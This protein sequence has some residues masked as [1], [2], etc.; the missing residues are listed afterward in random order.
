MDYKLKVDK[1]GMKPML[2][3]EWMADNGDIS[4][5]L[6]NDMENN[7]FIFTTRKMNAM[8]ECKKYISLNY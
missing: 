8:L 1:S 5:H 4:F 2:L 6:E 7:Q 3:L